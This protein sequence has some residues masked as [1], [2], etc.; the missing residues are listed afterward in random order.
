M[1]LPIQYV[2]IERTDANYE[3]GREKARHHDDQWTYDEAKDKLT[4][5]MAWGFMKKRGRV[6]RVGWRHTFE[7]LIAAGIP[8]IT[9]ESLAKKFAVDMLKFPMGSPEEVHDAIYAE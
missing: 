6:V 4:R 8:G 3:M 9:R 2:V 1:G 5:I 7:R